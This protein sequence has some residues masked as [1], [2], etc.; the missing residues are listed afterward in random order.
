MWM[1]IYGVFLLVT[2]AIFIMPNYFIEPKSCFFIR[3][4]F[5]F[6]H[7]QVIEERKASDTVTLIERANLFAGYI[8]K[9]MLPFAASLPFALVLYLVTWRV[10]LVIACMIVGSVFGVRRARNWKKHL[11]P[12][13]PELDVLDDQPEWTDGDPY[14]KS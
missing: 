3:K 11:K 4:Q 6:V 13:D 14:R 1:M 12:D 5:P 8:E 7:Y 10:E 9:F 2:A